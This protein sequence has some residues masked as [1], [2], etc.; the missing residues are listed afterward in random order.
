MLTFYADIGKVQQVYV[1]VQLY[2]TV[3]HVIRIMLT[4]FVFLGKVKHF[5][6][7]YAL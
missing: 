4:P 3:I 1:K 2:V 7:F 5:I 6:I